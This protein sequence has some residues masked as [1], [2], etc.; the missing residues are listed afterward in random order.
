MVT[1][2][3]AKYPRVYQN[4]GSWY[5]VEP[6]TN[7]WIRLC[8]AT[9]SE[10]MLLERLLAEKKRHARPEGT[11]DMRPLIDEYVRQ[12]KAQHREKKWP[13][14]GRYAGSGFRNANVANVRP[15]HVEKWLTTKYAD[16]LPMQRIMRAFLSGFFQWCIREDKI[17]L[18]PC[19]EVRLKKPKPSTVYIT[20]EHFAA[21]RGAMVSFTYAR[22]GG[23][24]V[25]SRVQSGEMMQ[26]FV[27]LCYLTA[28]RST[29]IR[30]LKWSQVDRAAGVIHFLPTKTE[31]SS[32]IAVDFAISPEIESVLERIRQIDGAVQRIGDAN[33]VHSL[34]GD[35]YE[36]EAFR[37]AWGRAAKR[38]KLDKLGYTVKSIRAKALTDAERAGYDIK[39]LQIAAA[40]STPKMT[41]DYI[42]Q[43][44]VPVSDVR[45]RIPG[46]KSA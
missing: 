2:K 16:K 10:E 32:G 31:D 33:V 12:H 46:A 38:V 24:I 14:Y 22:K 19:K 15:A 9:D 42:K 44:N 13:S 5:W 11:G 40:H 28:Q 30:L 27:D 20:D 21:I 8:K 18:N 29:D 43:R 35:A 36:P 37:S 41:E 45:L 17:V 23:S 3:K 1:R 34:K 7:K 6:A 4:D 26:C 25:T 39:A